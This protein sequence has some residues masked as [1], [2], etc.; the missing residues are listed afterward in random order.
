MGGRL[1]MATAATAG[2]E[3]RRGEMRWHSAHNDDSPGCRLRWDAFGCRAVKHNKKMPA[4][5]ACKALTVG[6][7]DLRGIAHI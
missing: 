5:A 3:Q 1:F 6:G 4:G 7:S 2:A